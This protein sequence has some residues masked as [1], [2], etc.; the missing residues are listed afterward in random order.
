MSMK[1]GKIDIWIGCVDGIN[2]FAEY[3]EILSIFR[4]I[5]FDKQGLRKK[6]VYISVIK[7]SGA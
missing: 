2:I 6:F 4:H 3:V 1:Q 7:S 5:V